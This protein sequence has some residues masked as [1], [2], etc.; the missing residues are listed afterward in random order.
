MEKMLNENLIGRI[1]NAVD[2]EKEEMI[3]QIQEVVRINSINPDHDE[4]KL[5]EA[6]GGETKVSRTL[7]GFM[8]SF[9]MKTDLFSAKDGREN[10]VGRFRGE[11][12][13]RSLLFNGHVDVVGIGELSQWKMAHPFSGDVIDGRIFG[14]GT[15]DMKAGLV[16]AITAMRAL[17]SAGVR[18]R[19]DVLIEAV[20]GEEQMDTEAGTGAC[21]ARGYRADAGIVMEG[22]GTP[23]ALGLAPAG[24]GALTFSISFQGKAGHTSRRDEICRAGGAGNAYAVSAMDKA[25]Y[26]Y[27]GLLRLEYDWG[28]SKS[29]PVFTRPG[30]FTINPGTIEAGPTPWAIP[31]QAKLVYTAWYPPHEKAEDVKRELVEYV[32]NLCATDT[33]LKDHPPEFDWIISWPPYDVDPDADICRVIKEIYP[34]ASGLAPLVHGFGAVTDATFLN[35]AGIPAVNMGPGDPRCSHSADEFVVIDKVMDATKIYALTMAAWCGIANS[36]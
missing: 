8:R 14:R 29:H 2:L 26:I 20:C 16:S 19:G 34:L 10:C 24:S 21:I 6:K 36:D 28:F 3:R 27:N 23:E 30:H 13:G 22:T 9:G 12:G 31:E 7:G 15:T 4:G 5:L 35:Q 11:G 32:L 18:L 25:I 17:V 1:L 33:W